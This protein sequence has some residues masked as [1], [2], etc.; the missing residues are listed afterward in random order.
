MSEK[1]LFLAWQ[2]KAGSR[3]WF[4]IGR[5]DVRHPFYHFRY[6]G[7]A[8]RAQQEAGFPP[9]IEFPELEQD[10]QSS[11][12]FPLF[13]NRVIAAGR[14]DRSGYL[15]NLD[16]PENANPF[17]ILSVNGGTR[18]TDSYEVFPKLVKHAD[19]SF[20][21]RFFL[22]GWRHAN[23]RAQERIGRLKAGEDLYVTLELTNPATTLA[24]QVQTTDY[25]MI[26]WTPRYL[27]TDLTA[28]M[29]ETANYSAHV[30]RVN[31]QPAP[32]KQRVLVEMRGRWD[33]HEPMASEDFMPLVAL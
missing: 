30:V 26:G 8:K 15:R 3:Q 27:V 29:A 12:L 25:H 31:P 21:C 14:P 1:T 22:H 17:E 2:D 16:L 20:D 4:P 19:G 33:K 23:P 28:A 13:S 18:V 11:E 32:S 24:V 5:L 9:L 6:T 7:G 10:Y